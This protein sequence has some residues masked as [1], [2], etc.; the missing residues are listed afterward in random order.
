MVGV[1]GFDDGGGRLLIHAVDIATRA[2]PTD[3]IDTIFTRPSI[4]SP[5]G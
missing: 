4:G 5:D 2:P 1:R 3:R